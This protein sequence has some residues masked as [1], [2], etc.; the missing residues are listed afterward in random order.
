MYREHVVCAHGCIGVQVYNVV[1]AHGCMHTWLGHNMDHSLC[2]RM[3]VLVCDMSRPR[4]V[5]LCHWVQE[6]MEVFFLAL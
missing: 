6:E 4:D 5:P 3:G 2:T 1:C